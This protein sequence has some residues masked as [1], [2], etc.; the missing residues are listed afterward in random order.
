MAEGL[1]RENFGFFVVLFGKDLVFFERHESFFEV[2]EVSVLF[3]EVYL[4]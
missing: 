4:C 1:I 3:D 2:F